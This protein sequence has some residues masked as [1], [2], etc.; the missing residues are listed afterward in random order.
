MLVLLKL[1]VIINARYQRDMCRY[2]SCLFV[3]SAYTF[4]ITFNSSSDF[5]IRHATLI[6]F[7]LRLSVCVGLE[8]NC[9][10][11]LLSRIPICC[12]P[13]DSWLSIWPL[14]FSDMFYVSTLHVWSV[15]KN[16]KKSLPLGEVLWWCL[17][18]P[19]SHA[20]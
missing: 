5:C 19:D 11:M 16:R 2:E 9:F 13:R 17:K 20:A 15:G 3:N 14:K 6:I 8:F 10:H 12:I 1:S 7:V 4:T 18:W